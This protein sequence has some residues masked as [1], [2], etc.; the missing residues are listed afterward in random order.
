MLFGRGGDLDK[1]MDWKEAT[2]KVDE[3]GIEG[4]MNDLEEEYEYNFFSISTHWV[5]NPRY[6]CKAKGSDGDVV[7]GWKGIHK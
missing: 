6:I 3:V 7:I 2:K 1:Y 4:F 5:D